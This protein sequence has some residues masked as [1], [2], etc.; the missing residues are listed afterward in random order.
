MIPI[1][2]FTENSDEY[3]VMYFDAEG[4]DVRSFS[5]ELAD[6]YACYSKMSVK[7]KDGKQYVVI[8]VEDSE[9]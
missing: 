4:K 6:I 3:I 7:I 9:N 8:E 5:D 1:P 2:A